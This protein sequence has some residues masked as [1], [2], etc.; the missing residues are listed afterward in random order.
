MHHYE[1]AKNH[2]TFSPNT[3]D[4]KMFAASSSLTTLHPSILDDL[5]ASGGFAAPLGRCLVAA[6]TSS[7]AS[8][9]ATRERLGRTCRTLRRYLTFRYLSMDQEGGGNALPILTARQLDLVGPVGH[10]ELTAFR[11]A[12]Q[13]SHPKFLRDM[14]TF[15]YD[16]RSVQQW[17]FPGEIA[18][19]VATGAANDR[20]PLLCRLLDRHMG[21]LLAFEVPGVAGPWINTTMPEA[22]ED[23]H[24]DLSRGEGNNR[25]RAAIDSGRIIGMG[26]HDDAAGRGSAQTVVAPFTTPRSWWQR[27]R[28][29]EVVD[30]SSTGLTDV[31][32]C[33]IAGATASTLRSLHIRRCTAISS[34]AT[35]ARNSCQQLT[36]LDA[37]HAVGLTAA[38]L[39]G[40]ATLRC[41]EQL[42]LTGCE[43]L[44][45]VSAL[46]G[47][48][49]LRRLDLSCTS[50][51]TLDGV[52]SMP[53]LEELVLDH[54]RVGS[55][56]GLL[57]PE[58]EEEEDG[59][60]GNERSQLPRVRRG[61]WNL[62]RLSA[63]SC[64]R[65]VDIACLFDQP[66][67]C[68]CP[69]LQEVVLADCCLMSSVAGLL[70]HPFMTRLDV[71]GS[72]LLFSDHALVP[73]SIACC[74]A[75]SSSS[76]ATPPA[77][78]VQ[79]AL[80]SLDM[81]SCRKLVEFASMS[82]IV[83]IGLVQLNLSR[84]AITGKGLSAAFSNLSSLTDLDGS[85]CKQL[86]SVVVGS[87]VL[88]PLL[89]RLCLDKCGIA[90]IE[91]WRAMALE[92][93]SMN[94]L[95]QAAFVD[96]RGLSG[97][98][99]LRRLS[100]ADCPSLTS[101]N[102]LLEDVAGFASLESLNVSR[103]SRLTDV[104]AAFGSAGSGSAPIRFLDVSGTSITAKGLNGVSR[105]GR[106]ETIDVSDCHLL[107][108]FSELSLCPHLKSLT[109]RN[110]HD[111]DTTFTGLASV[112][113]IDVS[114]S[115]IRPPLDELVNGCK[116][117]RVLKLN[118]ARFV[119][120]DAV[121]VTT[122]AAVPPSLRWESL[123]SLPELEV[124]E[125]RGCEVTAAV[126]DALEARGC[127]V[128]G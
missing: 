15:R 119:P 25:N 123:L 45:S 19:L 46:A 84:T 20:I 78:F 27:L 60:K 74:S 17:L 2:Q 103:C 38:G 113:T 89:R 128:D 37:S 18:L 13:L 93:L 100:V 69:S 4:E 108:S 31:G 53:M 66:V 67:V 96:L 9:E 107:D 36:M 11:C 80:T 8:S 116:H 29:I 52:A 95:K 43:R 118:A 24:D 77:H 35:L 14:R 82:S 124:I 39:D 51:T 97:C 122:S 114:R 54:S 105:L 126:A 56:A 104:T 48:P 62:R 70:R 57:M 87:H 40:I 85:E 49:S 101:A 106:L 73:R 65:L 5:V 121:A 1:F 83:G 23:D 12:L 6:P 99:N 111:I 55:L 59:K 28:R 61:P 112:E 44:D 16:C 58:E 120:M 90:S 88:P 98:N 10:A 42:V 32:L 125:C 41:L 72:S 86:E 79:S 3:H 75:V 22:C 102:G 21:S 47:A 109:A 81:S 68:A 110:C 127:H 92:D 34:L 33:D 94:G 71:S 26:D 64:S 30:V 7:R 115:S 50:V 63:A 91:P 117:L 76:S